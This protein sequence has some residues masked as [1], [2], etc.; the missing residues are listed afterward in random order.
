[1]ISMKKRL[2]LIAAA[3]IIA[4]AGYLKGSFDADMRH[5]SF[6]YAENALKKTGLP[7][8]YAPSYCL[9][10]FTGFRDTFLQVKFIVQ[11]QKDREELLGKMASA[12]GWH[13][14]QVQGDS[15]LEFQQ[16]CM[17]EYADVLDVPEDIVFDAWF[18]RETDEPASWSKHVSSGSLEDIGQVGNGFEFAV[19]DLETGLFIFVDQFG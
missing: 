10:G 14:A 6:S 3:L 9:H 11:Y 8:K 15:Y 2:L 1:M 5:E 19:Y 17:W 4:L 18:Y 16:L 13:I 12:K 7:E